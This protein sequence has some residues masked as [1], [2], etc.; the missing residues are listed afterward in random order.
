MI[1]E[2]RQLLVRMSVLWVITAAACADSQARGDGTAAELAQAYSG[3]WEYRYGDSPRHKDEWRAW[4]ERSA[5]GTFLWVQPDYHDGNWQE[6]ARLSNPPG[7]QGSDFLWLRTKLTGPRLRDA[8]LFLPMVDE[9]CEAYLDGRPIGCFGSLD[10]ATLSE[11]PG[12]WPL[13]LRLGER[14]SGRWLVIRLYSPYQNIGIFEQ[15]R[16][17]IYFL[18]G[19]LLITIGATSCTT[20]SCGFRFCR[21]ARRRRTMRR[22]SSCWL[23]G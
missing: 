5:Q 12:K 18:Y 20:R 14:Y 2:M 22:S 23:W 3:T 9:R 4:G 19:V 8:T 7:R 6:A 21:C 10:Q 16:L 13:Y 15:I 17:S 1:I 11:Y